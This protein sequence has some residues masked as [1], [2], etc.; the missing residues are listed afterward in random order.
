MF[1]RPHWRGSTPRIQHSRGRKKSELLPPRSNSG[2]TYT[3]A[4]VLEFLRLLLVPLNVLGPAMTRR[5][6][7]GPSTS[8]VPHPDFA[9]NWYRT[10]IPPEI[11]SRIH[12]TSDWKGFSQT[13]SWLGMLCGW[14]YLTI[15]AHTVGNHLLATVFGLLYGMQ[16]NFAINGM[17]E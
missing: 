4:A 16:A 11:S 12:R 15:W 7:L 13:I 17:H 10:K 8:R 3:Y 1:P 5:D 6:P 2:T 14:L 9:I